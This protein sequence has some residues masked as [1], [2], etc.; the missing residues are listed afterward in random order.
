MGNKSDL[1]E[2]RKVSKDEGENFAK[3][4]NL[5]MFFETSAKSGYNAQKVFIKAANLLLVQNSI[6]KF[7]EYKSYKIFKW[8][9]Y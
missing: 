2:E 6:I 1:E 9:N 3:E 8:K 7:S 5:D 4:N